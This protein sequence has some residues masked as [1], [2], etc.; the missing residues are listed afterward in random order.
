MLKSKLIQIVCL[1]SVSV[2]FSL[3]MSLF[4]MFCLDKY[5]NIDVPFFSSLND[6]GEVGAEDES[7]LEYD[8]YDGTVNLPETDLLG[9]K[10]FSVSSTNPGL[11]Y[12]KNYNY[13]AYNGKGWDKASEYKEFIDSKYSAAYLSGIVMEEN[14][15]ITDTL[16][17]Y[18]Y[19]DLYAFPTSLAPID[20]EGK[21]QSSDV[22]S[23]GKAETEYNVIYYSDVDW[24]DLDPIQDEEVAAF[25]LKYRDYVR[26]EYTKI[27]SQT[28][29]AV[30]AVI[31]DYALDKDEEID[32]RIQAV[33]T[34][35][36]NN[37]ELLVMP[38]FD[39]EAES[40]VAVAFL[41]KYKKGT[42]KNFATAATLMLR[43][44]DIPARYTEGFCAIC[45]PET[46]T[47]VTELNQYSWVE[48]YIDGIG[49]ISVDVMRYDLGD[50][51]GMNELGV[52][53]DYDLE[54][55]MFKVFA[56]T[57][58]KIYL[59]IESGGNYTGNGWLDAPEYDKCINDKYSAC[60]MPGMILKN[61]ITARM[62][63]VTI[64]PVENVIKN[65]FLLPYY[66]NIPTDEAFLQTS[67]T[68]VDG[69]GRKSYTQSYFSSS[70]YMDNS[71]EISM[72][73][74]F[75]KEYRKFV[76]D[77]YL[78]I[79]EETAAYMAKLIEENG[80]DK[81]SA[82]NKISQ[83]AAVADFIEGSAIYSYAY[84]KKLDEEA[85]VA[86]A[87]L[88]TYKQ[89]ICQHYASAAT[90]LFRALGIPARYTEGYVANAKAGVA[91]DVKAKNAHAWVE[92]YIDGFGW[93]Y[94]EVTGGGD[95]MFSIS[96]YPDDHLQ[97]GYDVG[98][99]VYPTNV[100]SEGFET[101][102]NQGYTI[103]DVVVS[104]AKGVG[105]FKTR[106]TS[107]K[108]LDP[109][110]ND[111][112]E[113]FSIDTSK[114]GDL[115][116][117]SEIV[118]TPVDITCVY[119]GKMKYPE[120]VD[121]FDMWAAAGYVLSE[122]VF[123]GESEAGHHKS[124]LESCKI[125]NSS[126]HDVTDYFHIDNSNESEL[127]ILY[128]IVNL[129]PKE[130]TSVYTGE[131]IEPDGVE[132]FEDFEKKGFRF[133]CT[134]P[135]F[136]DI[137]NYRSYIDLDAG[138][139]IYD[140]FG[141]DVT[142]LFEVKASKQAKLKIVSD[143]I[144]IVLSEGTP[145]SKLKYKYKQGN[146]YELGTKIEGFD[147][148]LENSY[149]FTCEVTTLDSVGSEE[150][151]RVLEYTVTRP[152]GSVIQTYTSVINE[153]NEIVGTY[154]V[155]D[156]E[157]K[158]VD[159]YEGID[160][161]SIDSVQLFKIN[162]D[163]CYAEMLVYYTDFVF[164]CEG[165]KKVYD[166]EPITLTESDIVID[167]ATLADLAE[168]GI[169][170]EIY[171]MKSITDVGKIDAGFKVRFTDSSG[172]DCSKYVMMASKFATYE[173]TPRLVTIKP[174]YVSVARRK[175]EDHP[176]YDATTEKLIY[177]MGVIENE[178]EISGLA[179]SDYIDPNTLIIQGEADATKL[180]SAQLIIKPGVII[181]D[182]SGKDVTRNYSVSLGVGTLEVVLK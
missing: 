119:D 135:E 3:A 92:V 163:E 54:K 8:G 48:V 86:V 100:L 102:K 36:R 101:F 176:F 34:F 167:P 129:A 58:E 178:V 33:V 97:I 104:G 181:R 76:Y 90:L 94:V 103:K 31:A 78:Y 63:S 88:E 146:T 25:E 39:L 11:V 24:R 49:W 69:D 9:E 137:G 177:K 59:K 15:Y 134:F 117:E 133:E 149:G 68:V 62:N 152:D 122:P 43:A 156:T 147:L 96:L 128:G 1:S 154:T 23:N 127:D 138:Y 16:S 37:Y 164:A 50:D 27:N 113:M 30:S 114:T 6:N 180:G 57:T 140:E 73:P 169:S 84:D 52:K 159:R 109:D 83:I 131:P 121:G 22:Y 65:Y 85:N 166:G 124:R 161:E 40:D 21:V 126:G 125:Y 17:V 151:A 155:F 2:V 19:V 66:A 148:Y 171:D 45:L 77:N 174:T 20:S 144:K 115:Y 7:A 139:V 108:I 110:G 70:T 157:G 60:Y 106:V 116:V 67:D 89:G 93:K 107:C 153:E 53:G 160:K 74:G 143:E 72:D 18:S 4:T 91:V 130:K 14:R 41:T 136:V 5:F 182:G 79:D 51:D 26:T 170:Y 145:G 95:T 105:H 81:F 55:L 142:D 13:G 111:V 75:E 80:L 162:T 64:I 32:K 168:N 87:F 12:L 99:T 42:V 28:R 175:A 112:T 179:G 132:G 71:G 38:D 56:S 141:E 173:I 61:D 150:N 172:N 123:S 47:E 165:E 82:D 46:P 118:L 35:L 10:Y 98:S 120:E 44:M 29:K 158:M